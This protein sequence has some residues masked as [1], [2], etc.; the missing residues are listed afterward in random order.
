MRTLLEELD[1]LLSRARYMETKHPNSA[2]TT[3]YWNRL[4]SVCDQGR[5][6]SPEILKHVVPDESRQT[7][8][9][10][11]LCLEAVHEAISQA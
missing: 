3:D 6:S 8:A 2:I 5:Q 9:E 10:A 4:V 7:W 1:E 11:L